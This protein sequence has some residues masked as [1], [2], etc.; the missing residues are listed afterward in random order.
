MEFTPHDA[1]IWLGDCRLNQHRARLRHFPIPSQHVGIV[2]ISRFDIGIELDGAPIPFCG[3]REIALPVIGVSR[4]N[5]GE[6]VIGLQF[7]NPAVV[8]SASS[9]SRRENA[10]SPA[11]MACSTSVSAENVIS[12]FSGRWSSNSR[13]FSARGLVSPSLR[14]CSSRSR[15]RRRWRPPGSR[16]MIA[17]RSTREAARSTSIPA[18][19]GF[20]VTNCSSRG[21]ATV[22]LSAVRLGTWDPAPSAPA[23]QAI[24]RRSQA[25]TP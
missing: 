8:L 9:K 20:A 3:L 16:S 1:V 5:R 19:F 23:G 14:A 4:K 24:C 15:A 21:R 12:P 7:E 25:R 6:I 13:R 18:S 2:A 22:R 10:A 17:A 11:R